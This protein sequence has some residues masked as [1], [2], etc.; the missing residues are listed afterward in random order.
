MRR[1]DSE[2]YKGISVLPKL[3]IKMPPYSPS[4]SLNLPPILASSAR[5]PPRGFTY[6]L[7]LSS[8]FFST[9]PHGTCSLSVSWSYL[10]LDGVYHRIWAALPSNL[11]LRTKRTAQQSCHTGLAPSM[12]DGPVQE[13]LRQLS[14][15]GNDSSQ[16]PHVMTSVGCQ[17]QR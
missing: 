1:V 15:T 3:N 12:G 10:V 13:G 9:F 5:L 2:T 17:I 8:K 6:Y 16:T 11:T 14:R 7:T 4:P